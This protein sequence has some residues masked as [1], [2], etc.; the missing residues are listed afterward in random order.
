MA[1]AELPDLRHK[2]IPGCTKNSNAGPQGIELELLN[3]LLSKP[4]VFRRELRAFPKGREGPEVE[5][6][7]GPM[8]LET[9]L[10]SNASRT[11]LSFSKT[12]GIFINLLNKRVCCGLENLICL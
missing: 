2:A 1:G 10:M 12:L 4:C 7:A 9:E 11:C 3:S 5:K 8:A 6:L